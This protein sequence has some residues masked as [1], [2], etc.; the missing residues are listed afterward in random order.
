MIANKQTIIEKI[1]NTI[2]SRIKKVSEKFY[3]TWKTKPMQVILSD[4]LNEINFNDFLYVDSKDNY[5]IA[6]FEKCTVPQKENLLKEFEKVLPVTDRQKRRLARNSHIPVVNTKKTPYFLFCIDNRDIVKT[7]NPNMKDSSIKRELSRR[8]KLLDNERRQYFVNASTADHIKEKKPLNS[9]LNFCKNNRAIVKSEIPTI[10]PKNI[11]GELSRR[12]KLLDLPGKN[13]YNL[14]KQPTP[15]LPH[16]A[17]DDIIVQD[18]VLVQDNVPTRALSGYNIFCNE[19]RNEAR[20]ENPTM[21]PQQI[22]KE[23]AYRWRNLN[24]IEKDIYKLKSLNI[25]NQIQPL[26]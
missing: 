18:D 15:I 9:F 7:E 13:A 25:K 4:E 22:V 2:N 11:L 12:W 26:L 20:I 10:K 21:K 16:E 24:E 1:M 8:W 6:E 17:Q 3:N 5:L 19:K 23:L 14:N